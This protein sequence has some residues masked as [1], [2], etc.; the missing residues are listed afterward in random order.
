M[1][2]LRGIPLRLIDTAG[3][4]ESDDEMKTAPWSGRG[5]RWSVRIW[6][7]RWWM[8]PSAGWR[9]P[10]GRRSVLVLNKSDLGEHESLARGGC[11]PNFL[12]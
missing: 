7:C 10:S 8:V 2:N 4:R 9:V 3:V 12:P 5:S 1:I 11:G 6:C